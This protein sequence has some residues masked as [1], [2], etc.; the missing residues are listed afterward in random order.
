MK[1]P[2]ESCLNLIPFHSQNFVIFM[3]FL[4]ILRLQ[5]LFTIMSPIKIYI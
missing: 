2:Y 5:M 4:L 3:R 1:G